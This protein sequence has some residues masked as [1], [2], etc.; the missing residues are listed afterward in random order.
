[1]SVIGGSLKNSSRVSLF[2][3]GV[4]ALSEREKAL[5]SKGLRGKQPEKYG[6]IYIQRVEKVPT[7]KLSKYMVLHITP[8]AG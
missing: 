6:K 1:M 8:T 2:T 4:K 5:C 7:N 3:L